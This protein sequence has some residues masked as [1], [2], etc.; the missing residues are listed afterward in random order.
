MGTDTLAYQRDRRKTVEFKWIKGHNNDL[1]NETA[2]R[3]AV[4]GLEELKAQIKAKVK[5]NSRKWQI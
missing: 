5:E 2:D 4:K 1:F 3:L